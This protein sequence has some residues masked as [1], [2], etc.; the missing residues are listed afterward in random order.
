MMDESIIKFNKT[1]AYNLIYVFRINDDFHKDILKVGLS[2]VNFD[3]DPNA[4]I[5]NHDILNTAAK[6]RI[7]QYTKTAG[8]VYELLYTELAIDNNNIAFR[9][10]DVHKVLL[11]SGIK[12]KCLSSGANEWFKTDLST[13]KNAIRAVKEGKSSLFQREI[14]KEKSPIILRP[15]QQEAVDKTKKQF[16]NNDSML[17]NAKMRFGKTLS[18]L[19]VVKDLKYKKTIIMTHRPVVDDGWFEDFEK[20]FYDTDTYKYGSKSSNHGDN[21]DTL[22]N[23]GVNYVYFI[24]IQDLRGSSTVGGKFDK[25]DKVFD[26]DWDLVI[27]DEA[28]EGTGTS[29]GEEVIKHIVKSENDH[30]TKLLE[31][32]GTPFNL[33]DK[34][35]ED[36]IYTWDYVMEQREKLNW[37]IDH[38]GD[39]N[40]YEDLPKM[41][42]FTYNLDKEIEGFNDYEDMAFNFREF[43][44]VWTDNPEVDRRTMPKT[45]K[46]GEFVHK[47]DVRHFLDLLCNNEKDSNYPFSKQEYREY[48]RHSL[49]M[50]PGVKEAKALSKMLHDHPVFGSG[51]FKIVNVAGEG[52]DFEEKHYNDAKKMVEDA[53]SDH[54]EDTY[55]ITLSCGRL[56]TGVS[57]KAWTAI[58]MLSGSAS[59]SA[60]SYLQTIFRAQTPAKIGGK[61]KDSCYVF[62][63]APD[64][65]L[66]MVAEAGELS[67]RRGS[68]DIGGQ[69]QMKEFLNFCPVIGVNGSTMEIYDVNNMLQQL[70]RA[71]A[72]RVVRNGFDDSNLYNDNLLRLDNLE[73]E[74]FNELRDIIGSTKAQG[75]TEKID[76]NKQGL[77]DEEWKTLQEAKKKK[78]KELTPEQKEALEKLSEAKKQQRKA[79]DILR[80]ISIR[81]PMLIYGADIAFD[82]EVTIDN[83]LDIVDDASW[84]EFMPKGVTK[85]KFKQFSKYYDV[86]VFIAAG[87]KIR[88]IAKSAD[89]LSP[90]ERVKKITG[91]F[92]TFKN[93]DKETVLTPWRVVN[94]HMSDTLGG[95]CFYD[96]T[97]DELTGKLVEPRYV[98]H[99]EVTINTLSTES[100]KILEINSKTGL[101]PLY[102][103]YSIYK[104]RC[105]N[106]D[107]KKLD[108]DKETELWQSTIQDNVFVVCKTQ[109][110]ATTTKRTLNGYKDANFNVLSY[111]NI[112]DLIQN[113][114]DEFCKEIKDPKTWKKDGDEMKFNAIVGNPPY[115]MDTGGSGRQAKPTYNLFVENAKKLKPNYVSMITPSRWFSG[116][117]GL[118]GFRKNM[119]YDFKM[120]K[121][122]DYPN[123]KDVFNTVDI[124]GGVSYFLWSL[125]YNGQ[126]KIVNCIADNKYSE[127]R[128]L[129][130]YST[131]VRF[132]Q[133]IP[134][135][136]KVFEI[137]K[138]KQTLENTVS[139]QKP[140][141]LPTNYKPKE[142]GIPCYFIQKIGKKYAD[143]KDVKDNNNLLNKWKL[144]V[145]R[146]P[147]AGQTD[148]TKPVGFYYD[149]NTN[150]AKPGECCTESFIVA[151]AF[152]TEEE[153][154]NFKSYLFTKTVRFLLLQAVVSQDV[155]RNKY[156]FVPS[157]DKYDEVYT[158][159]LLIQRWNLTDDEWN[160]IDSRIHNYENKKG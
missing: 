66:K 117:M 101:Y 160:Y 151:G 34:F 22:E 32:S 27:V 100:S 15:N 144:I 87:R 48:F 45:V 3:Y 56:T 128:S 85:D 90:T 47:D 50:I 72:D 4:I 103:T 108:E 14:T 105:I 86:D 145:P 57:I 58:F 26:I 35:E 17:W 113:Y 112:I 122:I 142:E 134:I 96:E 132:N 2:S 84:E 59:V 8:I 123:S 71:H 138:P 91:L 78:K 126:C 118:D 60:S 121:L 69:E 156:C 63:F 129:N 141:D 102:V 98:S 43:F 39:P 143:P 68:V 21:I 150:I 111:E 124:A 89:K 92:T 16:K 155:L 97:F 19:Q 29:L 80:G 75:K 83:F 116:G 42:I 54:P 53:I 140:F 119:M 136:R 104:Q 76:V 24:S 127:V 40:P 81:I 125:N 9:D 95:W 77:N 139:P 74:K 82:K 93:P 23:E 70:K 38:F 61:V 99:P 79:V 36:Q 6:K 115:Q 37:Y 20:I 146:S 114:S 110:A 106:C 120:I 64:R 5:P 46:I 107:T 41:N 137:E 18:A 94:M 149:G 152:D 52:D 157:L 133:A 1:F 148:F 44:R 147:I 135:I 11:N 153:V 67:T 55:T 30:K 7:D 13:V 51:A 10:Q 12:K 33:L 131:F 25:N 109:M 159:E 88:N 154:L 31:L 49:W 65:A 158:D 28:H 73:L 130:E 62:D